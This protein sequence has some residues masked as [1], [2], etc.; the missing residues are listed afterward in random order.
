VADSRIRDGDGRIH[1]IRNGDVKDVINY[2]KVY[3]LAVVPVDVVYDADLRSVFSILKEA[4]ER[5][6]AENPDV[7]E[8]TSIDGITAFGASTLTVRTSTRFKPD[9]TKRQ[10]R[11][12]GCRSRRRS[13]VEPPGRHGV[14]SCQRNSSPPARRIQASGP[15]AHQTALAAMVGC[16]RPRWHPT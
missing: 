3:T 16:H 1:I 10:P 5:L 9:V 8:D 2:L 6:R 11:R 15:V 14:A 4:G 7:L 13:I 12:F